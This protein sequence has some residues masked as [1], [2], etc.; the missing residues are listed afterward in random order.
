MPFMF[1]LESENHE[2]IQEEVTTCRMQQGISGWLVDEFMF[3][4]VA[5]EHKFHNFNS[6]FVILFRS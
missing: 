6:I 3:I 1:K 5:D 2:E 4:Y